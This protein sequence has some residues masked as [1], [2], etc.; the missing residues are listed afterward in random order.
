MSDPGQFEEEDWGGP[1]L[2]KSDLLDPWG[3]PYEYR[4]EGEVNMGSFDIISFGKDRQSGG[5]GENEDIYL[6]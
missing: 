1:Y 3:T 6:E 4:E 5:E 2:K